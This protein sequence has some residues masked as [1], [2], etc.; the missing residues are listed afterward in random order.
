MQ[1][2]LI[3][4]DDYFFGND[5][6]GYHLKKHGFQVLNAYTA[7]DFERLWKQAD[8][9]VLDIRLPEREGEPVDPWAGLR[10]LYAIQNSEDGSGRRQLEN[11]IIRSGQTKEDA[12]G[13]SISIP[14]HFRWFGP[15]VSFFEIVDTVKEV[16]QENS[17]SD[18]GPSN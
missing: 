8:V 18:D 4:E 7:S 13:A 1:R 3:V 12:I 14:K 17:V 15:D 11:C 16:A 5:V 6:L 2:I 10:K 9:I